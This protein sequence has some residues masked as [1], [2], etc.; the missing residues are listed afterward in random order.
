M[1]ISLPG[2]PSSDIPLIRNY[3]SLAISRSG[4][5][6]ELLA[7]I[8]AIIARHRRIRIACTGLADPQ[9]NLLR[10]DDK[11]GESVNFPEKMTLSTKQGHPDGKSIAVLS[12]AT[13]EPFWNRD[14][15][16]DPV[17]AWWSEHAGNGI[18]L[19]SL[20]ALPLHE[21][22]ETIGVFLL[23]SDMPDAFDTDLRGLLAGIVDDM[24]FAAC[25]SKA[26][27][28]KAKSAA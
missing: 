16:S 28:R 25:M 20:A 26:V 1:P 24:E 3:C 8:C 4:D 27:S 18:S 14:F 21:N 10:F 23:A 22:G 13:G 15:G 2:N 6:R 7:N 5:E 19:R 12:F 11:S 9:E 17:S